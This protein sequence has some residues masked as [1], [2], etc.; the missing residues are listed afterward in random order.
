MMEIRFD[1]KKGIWA[2]DDETYEKL[3][4]NYFGTKERGGRIRLEIEEALYLITFQNASCWMG[5]K[6]I[7]FNELASYFA[8]KDKRLFIKYNAYRDW[9]DRGLVVKS[10][11]LVE[12]KKKR[13]IRGTRY[14]AEKLKTKKLRVKIYWY[15]DSLFSVLEDENLGKK[16]FN[17]YWFGQFGIYKQE[18]G[19]LLKLNFLETIF[20]AKHFGVRVVNVENGKEI[21]PSQI[22]RQ[23]T[24]EREYTKS[25]YGVYEEWRLRGYVV[26]TGF[27][28]G[29]HFRIYFPGASPAKE[30]KWIHSK[31]VLHVF[32]KEQKLLISEWARAVR[33]AHGVKKTFL[34]SVPELKKKDYVNYPSDFITYRRKKVGGN[35]IRETLEDKARYLLVAVSEDEHI[36]GVELA[37][38]LAKAE[39][40][41][42][43]VL[44]SITD[45]E[46]SIT[47]YVLNKIKLPGSRY[48]YYEIEWMKP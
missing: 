25:L 39:S 3:R 2:E 15:P 27:K 12:I 17:D 23:V 4:K 42:L 41:G 21:K 1:P 30:E 35:W 40:M 11:D 43:N 16:L 10:I 26:K 29:S 13:K 46:T 28:F 32:P 48:E 36:G 37:S 44:L 20:L 5:K 8:K 31:H 47:Y 22:L 14:P 19:A 7:G 9:R 45:R 34:L 33:V 38:I 6:Q 18:R 24:K